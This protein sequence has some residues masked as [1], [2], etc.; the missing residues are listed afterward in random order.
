[1]N[2]RTNQPSPSRLVSSDRQFRLDEYE[3]HSKLALT[4]ASLPGISRADLSRDTGFARSTVSQLVQP[5]I[6]AGLVTEHASGPSGRG[7]PSTRL[8][9]NPRAGLILVADIGASHGR[10]V[11][12]DL[13]QHALAEHRFDVD[14]S[15]GPD[16]VLDRLVD[17]FTK[18]LAARNLPRRAVRAAVIGLPSPVDFVRGVCVRPPIMPDWDEF[19][20]ATYLQQ[21][22][23]APVLVDNDVNL[24][25]LGEA[26]TRPASQS[27]LLFAK[28]STGIGCGIVTADGRLHRG[29]DGAAGDIGHIRVPGHDD[30]LCRCGNIGCIEAVASATA[31]LRRLAQASGAAVMPTMEDLTRLV[32]ARDRTAIRLTRDAATQIG[33]VV[34]MLVHMFNPATIVLGGRLVKISDDLLAGVRA[35]VYQRALP[36][37]TRSLL[38]ESTSTATHAGTVGGIV[39][40]IEHVLS[41]SGISAFARGNDGHGGGNVR[42]P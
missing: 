16:V 1:M 14:L 19:P 11:V 18:L 20:V 35:V 10:L 6:E 34:A 7:R 40:G 21:R 27:P 12:A 36:L 28:I 2:E 32:K 17:D 25:A 23:R 38:V 9:I 8:S 31:L 39:L 29:T 4:I 24:M 26:R 5:L 15:L 42:L 13:G 37:A 3:I 33:E 30:T 41:A 22:L